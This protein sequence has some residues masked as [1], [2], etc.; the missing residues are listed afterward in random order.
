LYY[1]IVYSAIQPLKAASV[2]NK[3]SFDFNFSA[4]PLVDTMAVPVSG[5]VTV[6]GVLPS[7]GSAVGQTIGVT[8]SAAVPV[9]PTVVVKQP[10]PVRPYT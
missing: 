6:A 7:Q 10:E 8:V 2:L 4:P 9:A 1:C 5:I 3:I